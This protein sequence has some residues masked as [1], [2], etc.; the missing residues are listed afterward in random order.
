[1]REDKP[2]EPIYIRNA[3]LV[4]FAPFLPRLFERLDVLRDGPDGKPRIS[5][6]EAATRAV[7][8]L[9]YLVDQRL[10][11]P[12]PE[13]VLNKLMA[14]L[15]LTLPV[16]P[17]YDASEEER[18]VCDSLVA[19][20]IANWPIIKGTSPAGLRETFL[21]REGK[22]GREGNAW[23]LRVQRKTVDVLVDQIPWS[24]ALLLHRWMEHPI[25]VAW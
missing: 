25:H 23:K 20:T 1:M 10:D 21:Q 2:E 18:D 5:G 8:L 6:I 12:E 19:A 17:F 3:G 14:G 22:A 7:H 16:A 4:L 24:F 15:D 13:L 9:Q 11:T